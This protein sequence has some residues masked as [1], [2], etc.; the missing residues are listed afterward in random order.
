[1]KSIGPGEIFQCKI[2]KI[3]HFSKHYPVEICV[4]ATSSDSTSEYIMKEA[5]ARE[6]IS[7]GLDIK[8]RELVNNLK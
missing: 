4:W 1:M 2:R 6:E 3:L 5:V 7:Q 8:Q